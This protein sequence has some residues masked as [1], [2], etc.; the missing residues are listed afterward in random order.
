MD[1]YLDSETVLLREE[2]QRIAMACICSRTHYALS[3]PRGPNSA[4]YIRILVLLNNDLDLK[5]A[6][7]VTPPPPPPLL[8]KEIF[9]KILWNRM[10]N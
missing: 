4:Q 5:L 2:I 3:I 7:A 1:R 8:R 10:I 6:A 9:D